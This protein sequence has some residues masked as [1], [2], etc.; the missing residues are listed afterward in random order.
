M[1]CKAEIP[2]SLFLRSISNMYL[3]HTER[4][5]AN[6]L[7]AAQWTATIWGSCLERDKYCWSE[8]SSKRHRTGTTYWR[9]QT[10]LTTIDSGMAKK[11]N[12]N[13]ISDWY[14]RKGFS[15]VLKGLCRNGCLIDYVYNANY[16]S[17][18]AME[19]A[20]LLVNGNITASCQT[21]MSSKHK[22]KR[23]K[24]QKWTLRKN[25]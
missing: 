7:S 12:T 24:Q 6:T 8:V 14:E 22:I 10:K 18:L 25:C 13:S 3:F 4:S 23:Y 19:L 21:N 16:A 9:T 1:T 2:R 17:L 11:K 5:T 20:K 15:I